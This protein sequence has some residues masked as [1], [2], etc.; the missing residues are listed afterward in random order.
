ML[1]AIVSFSVR[2]RGVVITLAI[3]A[4]FYG[5]FITSRSKYDVFP[6]FAP[7]QIIIQT[8]APGYSPEQVEQLVTRPIEASVGGVSGLVTMRSQSIQGLSVIT[9]FFDESTD[10]FRN[11]QMAGE[12]LNDVARSLPAAVK[13]P[14]MTPLTSATSL[15][16]MAGLTSD[17]V[18][19]MALRSF[20]EYE[21]KPRLLSVPGVS[22]VIL[23]G[24]EVR[25]LQIQIDPQKLRS[26]GMSIPEVTESA[27][28]S[29][30]IKGAGFI[31]TPNQRITLQGEGQLST[32]DR[33]GNAIVRRTQGLN[34]KLKDVANIQYAPEPKFGDAQIS[35]KPAVLVEI[36]GQYGANTL[37]VTRAVENEL[38]RTEPLLR[39][40]GIALNTTIF[41]PANFIHTAIQNITSSLAVGGFLVVLVLFL[42]L[43]NART[44]FIS[45]TAIP[46]S[47]LASIVTLDLVGI[48]LNTLTLGG[49]A[50]AIGEVVDDA[51]IDVENIFRRLKDRT[52]LSNPASRLKTVFDASVEVR[53]SVVYA[54]FI[55]VLVFFPV[56]RMGG[57]QGK[58]FAPLGYSYIIAILGSL[59]VAL[60]LTPALSA[61][62]LTD[63]VLEHGEPKW[64][65]HV[66]RTFENALRV[67]ICRPKWIIGATTLLVVL[68]LGTIPFL[69]GSF[70]PE[71]KE[72][73]FV[74]HM[75]EIPGTSL[76]ES[77][78]IG[79]RV[80]DALE[81]IPEVRVVAQQV[82]RAE[83]AD[84]LWGPHYSEIHV[85]LKPLS[86]EQ[87]E[88]A[89]SRIREVLSQ[90][91]G[92]Y[93]ALKPFLT[94][95]IEETISGA[96]AQMAVKIFGQ[97][98]NR[99]DETATKLT[100]LVSSIK[101]ARNVRLE[102]QPSVQE[103]KIRLKEN[104]LAK[105]GF[106]S[107]V[108]LGAIQTAYQGSAVTQVYEGNQVID[109]V[110]ILAPNP[111][112]DP[113]AL[114]EL[115]LKN[116]DGAWVR[117]RDL[118]DIRLETGRYSIAHEK[119]RRVE[120]VT[121]DVGGADLS[122]FTREI[123]QKLTAPDFLPTGVSASVGGTV[124]AKRQAQRD[125]LIQSLVAAGGII[126]LL[127]TAL[128]SGRNLMLV[129]L[130]LP[131]ALVGGMFA[132]F[133]SGGLMN[134]GSL[135]GFVSLFGISTRNSIMLI[136]HFQHLVEKEG[137][138]WDNETA[139]RG[140]TERLLPILMTATVTALG[141]FISARERPR[142][143]FEG[144]GK[145]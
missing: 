135:V 68:A 112:R 138:A 18:D 44:S 47:L 1:D 144:K 139:I 27:A 74:I 2:H 121:F 99:M 126:L 101:G 70:L 133:A 128:K 49:L 26:F 53:H 16:L 80:T 4:F 106:Q 28:F 31:E 94:E 120:S 103:L 78:R 86:G 105:R 33:L 95:R 72:G 29:T 71:F 84:D 125:L 111:R 41:R 75:S 17:T 63:S 62:L 82:G 119:S 25:Q 14:V 35:G 115:L 34:V 116:P 79:R 143:V 24:G 98:L 140:A 66:K 136:S 20:A 91:P 15:V 45:L 7:P 145:D 19:P 113:L 108:V 127:W 22:K 37:E 39:G 11:R 110:T 54:T 69:S 100:A 73:H 10:I 6:E 134:L 8:E 124:E 40:K 61:V 81:K 56:I 76:E 97:D 90:F 64:I 12:R 55:V 83:M 21:M 43:W 109:V 5:L 60:T 52:R 131:L 58:I 65:A 123:E 102:S 122:S 114:G 9:I 96:T 50:I 117:L 130:N 141:S 30:A 13:A 77:M 57:V 23:F 129:L 118:A 32:P 93:F 107:P 46:L 132:V 85:D 48:S 104:E 87:A 3:L 88:R 142:G 59:I 51:V 38:K 89:E 92:V 36:S 137:A 42:F 67:L